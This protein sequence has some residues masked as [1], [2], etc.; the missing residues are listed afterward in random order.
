MKPAVDIDAEKE[1]V[2]KA[3]HASIEWAHPEKKKDL[4]YSVTAQD[5]RLFIFNPDSASVID[6]FE[7]FREMTESFFMHPAFKATGSDI[8]DLRIHLSDAGDFA[9]YSC[10]LDDFGE[11]NGTP[12]A[13]KNTRWTGVL[14][15]RD[16]RWQIVQM[17]F[18]FASDAKDEEAVEGDEG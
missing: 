4:L 7:S 13:W 18:S 14:E 3:V 11:V 6:G 12:Y 16:G 5:D 1:A 8:R 9:W 15:K 10:I 17:H 2:A